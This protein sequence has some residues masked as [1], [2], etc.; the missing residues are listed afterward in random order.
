MTIGYIKRHDELD[1]E[2]EDILDSVGAMFIC[3]EDDEVDDESLLDGMRN[4]LVN[5]FDYDL[6]NKRDI[7]RVNK[8]I[9]KILDYFKINISI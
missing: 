2:F 1:D 8:K 6:E 3:Y 7:I 9:G 4:E 5:R